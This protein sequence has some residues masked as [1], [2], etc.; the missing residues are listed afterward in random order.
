MQIHPPEL[1]DAFVPI[2]G[3]VRYDGKGD[4]VIPGTEVL[5]CHVRDFWSTDPLMSSSIFPKT[6]ARNRF[7][8]LTSA[9]H[10]AN[11]EEER[12]EGDRLF[13]LHSILDVLD[14]TFKTVFVPNKN[15]SVDE[16]LWAF[17]RCY[18]ALQYNPSKRARRGLKVYKFCSSDGPKAGY[19]AAST[20][21][22]GKIVGNSPRA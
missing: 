13:K 2:E 9:M 15:V 6:M 3:L 5:H 16:S 22:W 10:Y 17:K 14:E 18:H 19:T 11:N 12:Q 21:T 1:S 4:V 7:D 20:S 8:A